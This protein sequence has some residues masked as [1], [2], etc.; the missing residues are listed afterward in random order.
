MCIY[1]IDESKVIGTYNVEF[2]LGNNSKNKNAVSSEL[3]LCSYCNE[4]KS[5]DQIE[6]AEKNKDICIECYK[7]QNEYINNKTSNTN[8]KVSE[9]SEKSTSKLEQ[10]AN[11]NICP[12]CGCDYTS[13]GYQ[14]VHGCAYCGEKGH[15]LANCPQAN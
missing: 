1:N 14:W 9:S 2:T 7:K 8:N 15:I 5:I 3:F 10:E 4:D 12:D 13:N 6:E 11:P